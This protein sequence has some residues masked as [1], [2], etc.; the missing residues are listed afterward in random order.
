MTTLKYAVRA[1]VKAPFMT[2]VAVVSL[3]LGIGANAAIF[4]VFDEMEAARR[5][6]AT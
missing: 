1:L 5:Y 4:S 6:S 3:A 2:T